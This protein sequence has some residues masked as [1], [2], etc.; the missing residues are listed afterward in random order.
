MSFFSKFLWRG[1]AANTATTGTSTE[2]RK[3]AAR[4]S[5]S[6]LKQLTGR[7]GVGFVDV[8][9][10]DTDNLYL[11]EDETKLLGNELPFVL[12]RIYYP[13]EK[14]QDTIEDD[15][16]NGNWLPSS[17]YFPGYGYFL[18]LPVLVSSGIGRIFAS[19]VKIHAKEAMPLISIADSGKEKLPVVIFS[20]GLAGMRT[21]YST[22]CCEVASRGIIVLALEHRDGSAS[23]TIDRQG[24]VYPYQFGPSGVNLPMVDY[25][26]RAAQLIHRLKEIKSTIEFIKSLDQA[27]DFDS[28]ILS[29]TTLP[30]TIKQFKGR[31]LTER[32]IL[33]GHSFGGSTC[34]AAAQEYQN[35][36][37]CVV[38][39][40]WMFPMPEPSLTITRTDIDTLLII[41]EM[42]TWPENDAAIQKFIND[43][44][45][46]QNCFG[47]ARMLGS[48]HMDQSDLASIIPRRIIKILRPTSSTPTNH[49]RVLQANIDLV[50]AHLSASFPIYS[51]DSKW[52]MTELS[53][54]NRQISPIMATEAIK[55]D[56]T[57]DF[58]DPIIKLENFIN[59]K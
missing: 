41:N 38:W 31:L 58:F 17:H 33:M 37:C 5:P 51:F 14:S 16:L 44:R 54:L 20:H 52:T 53:T 13:T 15:K 19:N 2:I 34:L 35:V 57:D 32:L 3:I 28:I 40:P 27:G 45:N 36:K 25:E 4:D 39:D 48:G 6:G 1:K 26:F 18:R 11:R 55:D 12:A 10:E 7:F 9:W 8:E 43:F 23:M 46:T 30:E 22:I 47:K 50:S 56:E 49:H 21:T 24:K 29:S 59:Y 42:F